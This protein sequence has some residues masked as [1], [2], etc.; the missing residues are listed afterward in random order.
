[1]ARLA[2]PCGLLAAF[3]LLAP[4]P[5]LGQN[6]CCIAPDNGSGTATMPPYC[7]YSGPMVMNTG[8]TGGSSINIQAELTFINIS[9]V[10]GGNLGGMRSTFDGN[11]QMTMSGQGG[12]AGLNRFITMYVTGVMDFA[13]RNNG[14]AVQSF[15]GD[16]YDIT[17]EVFGDPDFCTLRLQGGTV[18]GLPSPGDNT[19]TRLGLPG[20]D[21]E[22]DSFFDIEYRI[23]FQGCPG[24]ALEGMG[25]TTQETDR[26]EL[27]PNP[28]PTETVTWGTIKRSMGMR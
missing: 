10:P 22:V 15:I 5:A 18:Y 9:S 12:L 13:P 24:S 27:C 11:L 1:M 3:L 19:L 14:D 25:G 20:S 26:F 16:L 8:F 4:L 2:I 6:G 17:G 28:V 7:T 21:F 23:E